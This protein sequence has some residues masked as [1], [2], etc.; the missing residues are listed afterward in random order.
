[1]RSDNFLV[2]LSVFYDNNILPRV[3]WIRG[4]T[5]LSRNLKRLALKSVAK[6]EK[7]GVSIQLDGKK[8]YFRE[9]SDLLYLIEENWL[10]NQFLSELGEDKVVY[11]VGALFGY[12]SVL[13]SL[14]KEVYSF[15]MDPNNYDKLKKNRQMNSDSKINIFNKAVWNENT[16]INAE[17]G[18]EGKS[19]VDSGNYKVDSVTLDSFSKD[20]KSPD[21][22]KIDVEV[23]EYQV[24]EGS[25]NL[26]KRSE[27]V[28]LIEVHSGELIDS[29]WKFNGRGGRVFTKFRL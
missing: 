28:I 4:T 16:E 13:G 29:F 25:K 27:P 24:L 15:E 12:Y 11:D 1:M 18:R 10:T 5:F 6:K 2:K 20:Y 3:E 9:L 7:N 8:L 19:N 26:L 17:I 22:I 14:G 23:A 21:I